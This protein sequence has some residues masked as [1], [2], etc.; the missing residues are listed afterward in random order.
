MKRKLRRLGWREL[1]DLPDLGITGIRVK[2]DTGARSSSLHVD[3]METYHQ[4]GIERVRFVV[5]LAEDGE[6]VA[7]DAE[8]LDRREVTDSGGHTTVRIFVRT[9]LQIG[10][11][12]YPIEVNLAS[13]QRML[14]PM[15]LGR[16]ALAGRWQV[17]PS[18]SFVLQVKKHRR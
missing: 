1:V 3:S 6:S 17:D 15:L 10:G 11:E 18:R 12:R 16:T 4:D 8:V 14:F 13:R 7:A 5:R 2:V 9:E